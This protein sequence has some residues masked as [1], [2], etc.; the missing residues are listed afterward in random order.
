MDILSSAA[1]NVHIVLTHRKSSFSQAM[2]CSEST[3]KT[4]PNVAIFTTLNTISFCFRQLETLHSVL[5]PRCVSFAGATDAHVQTPSFLR[6]SCKQHIRRNTVKFPQLYKEA[7]NEKMSMWGYLH[8][9]HRTALKWNSTYRHKLTQHSPTCSQNSTQMKRHILTQ[10][11]PTC[12]QNSAQMKRHI[13]TQHSP[14]C[15]QNSAQIKW[16][17]WHKLIW[18][19][20]MCSQNNAQ[21]KRHI[22]KRAIPMCSQNSAQMKRHIRTQPDTSHANVSTKLPSNETA[23]TDPTGHESS[24]CVHKI[25]L[26]LNGTSLKHRAY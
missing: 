19:I 5:L 25:V 7:S 15:S 13:L 12:S 11:S 3:D 18:V 14:T 17:I 26:K 9:V 10:H 20:P 1:K 21:M 23:H 4:Q 24:Q 2:N 22:R 8:R 16:H 6:Y